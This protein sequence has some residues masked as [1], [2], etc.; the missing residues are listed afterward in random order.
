MRARAVVLPLLGFAVAC[1]EN[2]L[3]DWES[4]WEGPAPIIEV[5]PNFLDFWTAGTGELVELPFTIGNI[6]DGV[7]RVTEIEVD[8]DHFA[9]VHEPLPLDLSRDE[10]YEV[11]VRFSPTAPGSIARQAWVV[12]NDPE[13]PRVPVDL[14][15]TGVVPWLVITPE[16]HDFGDVRLGCP[17]A[18]DLS[19]RNDGSELLVIDAVTHAGDSQWTTT[20]ELSLPLSLVPG[21]RTTLTVQIDPQVLGATAAT[22]TVS[23]NDPRGERTATQQALVEGTPLLEDTFVVPGDPAVDLLVAV[24]RSCSMGVHAD[25]L[26]Q[27]FGTFLDAVE[28]VTQGWHLGVV[29]RDDAC[30]NGGILAASTPDLQA[31]FLEAVNTGDPAELYDHERLLKLADRALGLDAPGECNLGFLRANAALHVIVV[32]DEPEQSV[33]EASWWTWSFWIGEFRRLLASPSLLTVSGVVDLDDCAGGAEGYVEAIDE[34]GGAK[35]SI[36]SGDWASHALALAQASLTSIHRFP[37]SQPADP[38][39]ISVTLDG[40]VQT[41]WRYDAALNAVV[42]DRALPEG[43]TITV[44]Y[45]AVA[46]CP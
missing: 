44:T 16:A 29:T 25:A 13:R 3:I 4:E 40:E 41:D 39:G 42:F 26:A 18:V 30:F 28:Q 14:V 36:C 32:S 12:S 15:G 8:P 17:D 27:S 45:S 24:D 19:L 35:L 43:A 5:T 34:T 1:S 6:G 11:T 46:S 7:L 21:A 33:D 10:T 31:A 38:G 22:L 9:V 23:S 2:A 20:P 37:L